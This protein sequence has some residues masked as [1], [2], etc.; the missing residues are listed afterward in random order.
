MTILVYFFKKK[1]LPTDKNSGNGD[2][3]YFWLNPQNSSKNIYK[4]LIY[5]IFII[6]WLL[7][8]QFR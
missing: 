1:Y 5:G 6:Y 7:F 2:F 4:L 3:F 8:D